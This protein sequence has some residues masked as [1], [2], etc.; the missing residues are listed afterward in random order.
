MTEQAWTNAAAAQP[1]ADRAHGSDI[2][3][4]SAPQMAEY[5]AAADRIAA[6]AHAEVLDWG[7]GYGQMTTLLRD[8]GMAVRSLDYDPTV[9]GV[10]ER[11]LPAFAGSTML[12]TSESVALPYPDASFDA[13][14][15]M[16]VLEHVQDPEGSLDEVRRVLRPGG[17]LY[18]YKLPNVHSYLEWIARRVPSMYAHGDLEFDRL[19]TVAS[20][21][22]LFERHGYE[23][24]DAR[25]ANMLPLTLPGELARRLAP[26][27]WRASRLLSAVPGLRRLATNVQVIART[28]AA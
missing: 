20:A 13:V 7:C 9:D 23:V 21:V 3:I 8:R 17:V 5:V 6:G 14:L 10:A 26:V 4:R 12:A 28:P 24:L 11:P 22:E 1:A 2:N 25:Y 18:C 27:I 16:G 19:Y 15:S